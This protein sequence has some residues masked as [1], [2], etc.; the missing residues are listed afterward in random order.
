MVEGTEHLGE[1]VL[2][3]EEGVGGNGWYPES[4]E[5][6]N[7]P[8]TSAGGAEARA[9]GRGWVVL[10]SWTG[11]GQEATL[12]GCAAGREGDLPVDSRQSSGLAALLQR[13]SCG[14]HSPSC[15]S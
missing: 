10:F 3:G 4:L 2:L 7:A 9:G 1:A 12:P 14:P 13:P 15:C 6:R 8:G 5:A 11:R